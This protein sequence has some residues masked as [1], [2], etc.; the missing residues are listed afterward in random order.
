MSTPKDGEWVLVPR[1]PTDEMI[2]AMCRTTACFP[3]SDLSTDEMDARMW[4]SMI[5]AAPPAP[6]V[7]HGWRPIES[8]PRDGTAI[9]CGAWSKA[10]YWIQREMK[11]L[12]EDALGDR[13]NMLPGFESRP[14]HWQPLPHPPP[15]QLPPAEPAKALDRE[16]VDEIVTRL[17][18]EA[19]SYA[20]SS[21]RPNGGCGRIMNRA[22][23]D[24]L[25]LLQPHVA[26]AE[27]DNDFGPGARAG[28]NMR[29]VTTDAPRPTIDPELLERVRSAMVAA[30]GY[31]EDAPAD[32]YREDALTKDLADLRAILDHLTNGGE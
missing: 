13:G 22:I 18:T 31:I 12:P 24:I 30:I 7:D 25:A 16:A 8:A 17:F 9:W 15:A 19:E 28:W 23:D 14:T 11:G 26:Q 2:E 10:G 1:E 5:A 3:G 21:E 20:L 27:G 29:E 4:S 6:A 32:H